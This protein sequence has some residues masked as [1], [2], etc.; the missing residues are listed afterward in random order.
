[1]KFNILILWGLISATGM[2]CQT[3]NTFIGQKAGNLTLGSY[4]FVIGEDST[5]V[6]LPANASYVWYIQPDAKFLNQ[7][8][9]CLKCLLLAYP[10]VYAFLP[11]DH[12][13]AIIEK[14][15]KCLPPVNYKP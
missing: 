8:P 5:A 10:H 15:R 12:A 4:N 13:L 1:M 6:N 9:D 11:K 7:C 2:Y 14:A 3:Y